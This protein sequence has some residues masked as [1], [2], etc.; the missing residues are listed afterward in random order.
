MAADPNA[1]GSKMPSL[2]SWKVLPW[3][4][5]ALS[6]GLNL[7]FVG[8]HVYGRHVAKEIVKKERP[9]LARYLERR[10][11]VRK[12]VRAA[13]RDLNL[14]KEQRREFRM[15]RRDLAQSGRELRRKNRAPMGRLWDEFET[16][17][18][19]RTKVEKL[20]REMADNRYAFQLEATLKAAEFMASLSPEQRKKFAVIARERNIF[21]RLGGPNKGRGKR[22]DRKPAGEAGGA[23]GT[24]ADPRK[25]D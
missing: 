10:K 22:K 23:G 17:A 15:M 6:L 18:P 24:G 5:L 21:A 1:G 16:G 25:E 19:D 11:E 20:L 3:V 14:S 2:F 7:F 8:G 12:R 4:I 13:M 9:Q